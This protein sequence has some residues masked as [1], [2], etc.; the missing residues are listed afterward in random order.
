MSIRSRV[1]RLVHRPDRDERGATGIFVAVLVSL[2]LLA[3]AAFA[4][5]LGMQ[6]AGR[7]DMQTVADMVAL[8]MGRLID[9]RTRAQIEAGGANDPAAAAQLN[10]SVANNSGET[11]GEPPDVTAYWVQVAADGTYPEAGGIPVQ[12]G[13]AQVPNGVVIIAGTDLGF[14]FGGV[15]GVASGDVQRSAVATAEESAC[16]S[17]GSY[18]ARLDTSSSALLNPILEG[19][20]GGG[21]DLDA[22]SYNGLVAADVSLLDLA[23]ELG[24][25]SVDELLA[26]D[27]NAGSL[28]IAAANVLQADGT[29]DL[30]VLNLVGAQLGGIAISLGDLVTAEPGAGAAE[31]ATINVFDLLAGTVLIANGTNA[32]SI[33]SL[34]ANL[35]LTGT[36]LTTSLTLI[37]K[38]RQRCGKI[39]SQADTAQVALGISGPVAALPNIL[40]LTASATADIAVNVASARGILTDIVCG[41]E[42]AADPSGEDVQVTSGVVGASTKVSV[43]LS[44]SVLGQT[45]PGL[46]AL[47]QITLA[48]RLEL[49]ASTGDPST[50][51]N[52]QIRVPN[53][54]S[55]WGEAY[56]LGSGDLGL[57]TANVTAT[58]VT[59]PTVTV[60]V[61]GIPI[62]LNANQLTTLLTN[63][64][65]GV[66][67]TVLQPVL[68]AVNDSILSPLFD[69][70]GLNVGGADVYGQRPY[71]SNPLLVG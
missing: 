2:V 13:S 66:T 31:T 3:T 14:S 33:P 50:V 48:G 62:T 11:I 34:A 36:G 47:A 15:T 42:T 41:S 68:T 38:A 64:V 49:T 25:G 58:W 19:I 53:N 26:A 51:R 17:V 69:L 45:L 35:P 40:G 32:L 18:A 28:L 37:E 59:G 63:V 10:W 21:I 1:A 43:N 30:N 46:S 55:D 23:V 65:T 6:R 60:R 57:N 4:I 71:C 5:D 20:L 39:G 67:N 61:L 8:D 16:F 52:A 7:R 22:L 56:P 24:L 29:S 44:G 70:L 9:G 54:P 12:V 27:V